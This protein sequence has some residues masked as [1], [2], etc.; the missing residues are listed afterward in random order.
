MNKIKNVLY[1]VA[2]SYIGSAL[3]EITTDV[4][5]AVRNLF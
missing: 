1:C 5:E 4:I 3:W 2:T